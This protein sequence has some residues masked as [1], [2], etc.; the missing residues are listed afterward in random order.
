MPNQTNRAATRKIRSSYFTTTISI[1]LVLFLL[2][3]IGLLML[4]ANRVSEY[5]KENLSLT[6]TFAADA[7]EAE[8]RQIEK[9]LLAT[10]QVKSVKYIDKEE[11]ARQM[12]ENLGEDFVATLDMNPLLPT[13][14]VKLFA[15]YADER[16]ME[17]IAQTVRDF[18]PVREVYFEQDVVNLIHDNIRRIS[19]VLLCFS[20]VMLLVAI[21]LIN[22]TVRLMVYSKRFLIRTMQLVGATRGFIRRPFLAQGVAQGLIGGLLAN[23]MLAGVI[24]LAAKELP[25]VIGFNDVT[26]V[27]ALFVAVFAIGVLMTIASTASSVNKYLSLRT[28]DLYV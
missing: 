1:T 28:A 15:E 22:N 17:A 19:L 14:E 16:G 7:R 18:K 3:M 24:F 26:S 5:V 20:A 2:G 25:G 8:I 13:M 6:V 21:T 12:E 4:N 9:Q 23:A 11:A 27:A 10:P